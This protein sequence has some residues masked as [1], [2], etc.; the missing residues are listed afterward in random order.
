LLIYSPNQKRETSVG[1]YFDFFTETAIAKNPALVRR[2]AWK[3]S[4]LN[5]V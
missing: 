5:R 4:T 1:K 2:E 3:D